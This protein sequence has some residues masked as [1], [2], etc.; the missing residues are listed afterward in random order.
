[1]GDIIG[2]LEYVS[3][4]EPVGILNEH[5]FLTQTIFDDNSYVVSF[6]SPLVCPSEVNKVKMRTGKDYDYWF[7]HFENQ[8]VV[9]INMYD[10]SMPVQGGIK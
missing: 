10:L 7:R 8:D 4:K 9:M 3:G 6:R 5:E 2:Y 1:M